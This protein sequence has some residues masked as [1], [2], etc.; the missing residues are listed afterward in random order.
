ML[1]S[2][3]TSRKTNHNVWKSAKKMSHIWMFMFELL[4]SQKSTINSKSNFGIF[5]YVD[6]RR[7]FLVILKHCVVCVYSTIFFFTIFLCYSL[8]AFGKWKQ[9][10]VV[11]VFFSN[12]KNRGCYYMFWM[13]WSVAS[14]SS[15]N[16]LL[17]SC[18]AR[19]SSAKRMALGVSTKG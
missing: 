17:R 9:F 12:V 2:Q 7:L 4:L 14:M 13:S 6:E 18:S 3:I 11:G 16:I 15:C 10:C 5:V 1:K 8:A 19:N